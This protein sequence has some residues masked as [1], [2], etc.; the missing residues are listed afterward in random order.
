MSG[1]TKVMVAVLPDCDYCLA[2]SDTKVPAVIDGK[3]RS[4]PWAN[5]CQWHY[6]VN[7]IG[8]GLGRGQRM[9]VGNR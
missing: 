2:E 5:M 7:G 6:E 3:T 1:H 4:G 8:L 9:V